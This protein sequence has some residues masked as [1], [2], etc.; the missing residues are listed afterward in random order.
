M[1]CHLRAISTVSHFSAEWPLKEWFPLKAGL[2]FGGGQSRFVSS[3]SR[4]GRLYLVRYSRSFLT[5]VFVLLA[6]SLLLAQKSLTTAQ[7]KDHIGEHATVCGRVVSTRYAQSSRGNPTFLNFD[8][9]YPSQVF[10]MLIWGSD[11][12]KFDEPETKYR[13]RQ[14]CV[15]GKIT[16]YRGTPEIVASDPSQVKVQ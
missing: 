15:T 9:P 7:A 2:A 13:E 4:D 1:H 16:E 5:A 10:T 6:S 8:Q 14:I 3:A 12:T 11:R